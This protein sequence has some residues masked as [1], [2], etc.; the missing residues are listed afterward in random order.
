[1]YTCSYNCITNDVFERELDL[2]SKANVDGIITTNWDVLLEKLFPNFEV[3]I[4]Q[5]K[6]LFSQPQTIAEIYKIHGCCTDPN[7]LVLTS[8]DYELFYKRN[9]Y[10][11]AKL[12]TVFIEHPVIF[13]GYSLSDNNVL[14]ILNSIAS[15]LTNDNFEKLRDH[16]IF[17]EWIEDVSDSKI[18]SRIITTNDG[19]N[20]PVTVIETNDFIPIYE[21]LAGIKRKFPAK[22]LR[23]M[24]E[25]LYQLVITNDPRAQI[26]VQDIDEVTN[27][28]SIEF[29]IGVGAI[30]K[31]SKIG[32]KGVR[33]EHLFMD[34]IMD[35]NRY[36]SNDVVNIALPEL[37]K[38]IKY[39][40]IF[41]Y[42]RNTGFL[43]E[44]TSFDGLDSRVKN[45]LQMGEKKF[46]PP[47]QY[48]KN[49]EKIDELDLGI[50][51]LIEKYDLRQTMNYIL[52][53]PREKI[54]IDELKSFLQKNIDMLEYSSVTSNFDT[55]SFR[56][57][58]CLYDWLCF[59]I[60]K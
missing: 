13:M 25:Q 17:V 29:V 18:F 41:K 12:L 27:A 36:N 44:K 35:Q 46:V 48:L 32:Y 3:F 2:L 42:L 24:K 7:S 40:P 10:L 59:G 14:Q 57:L 43:E 4:G 19:V 55:T 45:A 51:G 49:K 33:P 21:A 58:A 30:A 56:R 47:R 60:T 52:L 22:L 15:C 50:A 26:Y 28:S 34:L 23:Q 54:V 53:L 5:E 16:L 9:S 31:M 39:V 37:L 6:L 38:N 20:L 11:A 1:M 8:E